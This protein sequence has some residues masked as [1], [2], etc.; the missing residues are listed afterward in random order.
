MINVL[1]SPYSNANLLQRSEVVALMNTLHR[2]VESLEAVNKFRSMWSE[3]S[4][5][6]SEDLITKTEQHTKAHQV[7]SIF[8]SVV[9]VSD[10]HSSR[11]RHH[12]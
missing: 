3:M 4:S 2:F 1:A 9:F 11:G 6:D 12:W 5:T 7:N 10:S 8:F